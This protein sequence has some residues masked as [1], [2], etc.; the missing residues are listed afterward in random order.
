[1]SKAKKAPFGAHF[2]RLEY[3]ESD[4]LIPC[5]EIKLCFGG[6]YAARDYNNF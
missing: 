3:I 5:T 1:M 2:S 6:E 4:G